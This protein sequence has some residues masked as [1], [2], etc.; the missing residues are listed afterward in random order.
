MNDYLYLDF[1]TIKAETTYSRNY[2]GKIHSL[3]SLNNTHVRIRFG[4][5]GTKFPEFVT[6]TLVFND[7]CIC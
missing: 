4:A 6:F 7:T 3:F 2:E 1:G 5:D